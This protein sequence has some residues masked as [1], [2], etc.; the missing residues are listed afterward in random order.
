MR[1]GLGGADLAIELFPALAGPRALGGATLATRDG[2]VGSATLASRSSVAGEPAA[3][4]AAADGCG[5]AL[6]AAGVRSTEGA[7][8]TVLGRTIT[9]HAAAASAAAPNR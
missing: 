2:L 3:D 9:N 6:A 1:T 8:G 7:W 5:D 4:C